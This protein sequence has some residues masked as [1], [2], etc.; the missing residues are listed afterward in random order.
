[1]RKVKLIESYSQECR[2]S[3][4]YIKQKAITGWPLQ[5]L[6]AGCGNH[7]HLDL[8]GIEFTLTGVDLDKNA[9]AVR[10]AQSNDLS[11]MIVGDLRSLNLEK[12][13]YDIIYCSYVLEHIEGAKRVLDNFYNWSKPGGIVILKIPDCSSVQ[14]FVARATPFWFHMFY[15]RHVRHSRTAGKPGF[16]PYPTFHEPI[17]SRA[18]IHEYCRQYHFI[19]KEELGSGYYLD[20]QGLIAVLMRLFVRIVSLLSLGKLAWEYNDLIYILEKR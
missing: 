12:N 7:W 11:E 1:M 15:K 19:I 8:G 2:L 16:G 5:I 6:E 14:G 9:L 13:K 18:G 10:R 20:G 4:K 17:V 3:E